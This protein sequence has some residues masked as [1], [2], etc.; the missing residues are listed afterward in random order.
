MGIEIREIEL[1]KDIDKLKMIYEKTL[2]RSTGVLNQFYSGFAS[3]INFCIKQGYAYVAIVNNCECGYILAYKEPDMMWGEAV[4][5]EL[6][7]V[8]PEY[9]RRG[10]GT[11]LL[12]T[13]KIQ[14]AEYGFR[15]LALRTGCYMDAYEIYKKYGFKDTRDDQRFM[16]MGINNK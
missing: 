16:I 7:V 12:D 3:Y 6:L 14:A 4:Y 15:M 10:I 8:L 5:I 2:E 9:Q 13:I 1:N 11:K